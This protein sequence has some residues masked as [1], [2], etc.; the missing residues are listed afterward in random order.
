MTFTLA[1]EVFPLRY[2]SCQWNKY[3]ILYPNILN[4]CTTPL[5]GRAYALHAGVV[6]LCLGVAALLLPETKDRTLQDIEDE[7]RGRPLS[8]EEIHLSSRS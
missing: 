5:A 4:Y 3:T 2:R 1:G 6:A 8:S 7:F